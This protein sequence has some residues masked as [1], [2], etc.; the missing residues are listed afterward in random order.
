M[1]LAVKEYRAATEANPEFAPAHTALGWL[2]MEQS[3]PTEA[4]DA[5]NRAVKADP[6]DAQALYG[7]GRI[8]AA[9]GKRESAAENFSKA[10]RFEKDPAKKNAIM[11]ALFASGQ[12]GD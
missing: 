4:M 7:I 3:R 12:T 8:Y 1:D 6:E 5:F 11:N 9:K 2:L 10:I